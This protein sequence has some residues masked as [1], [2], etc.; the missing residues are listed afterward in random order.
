MS[1]SGGQAVVGGDDDKRIIQASLQSELLGRLAQGEIDEFIGGHRLIVKRMVQV[2]V[3]ID[4]GKNGKD[5][6]GVGVN[7][8]HQI[9]KGVGIDLLPVIGQMGLEIMKQLGSRSKIT[10]PGKTPGYE[11]IGIN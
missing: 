7:G 11:R 8:A 5:E 1:M 4:A 9:S 2:R 3:G 10:V 6:I